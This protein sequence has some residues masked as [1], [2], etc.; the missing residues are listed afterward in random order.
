M[1]GQ[2]PAA[3][4]MTVL[5]NPLHK[6]RERAFAPVDIA[7]LVFFRIAFGLLMMWDV[8]RYFSHHRIGPYW[9]APRLLFKYY[10]FSWVAPW[11]GD[12]LYVHWA[13]LGI[14]ALFIAAGFFYRASVAL[15]CLG[16][17]YT[18][19]LDESK[20]L[21][22]TYLVCLLS[23]LL[24][25]I[26]AHRAFSIDAWRNPKLRAPQV[27]AWTL[28]LLRAQIGMVY[29]FGGVAKISPDWMAGEP[30][31]VWL[32]DKA[33]NPII[34]RLLQEEWGVRALSDAGMVF[35]LG[36]VPLLLWKRTRLAAFFAAV[37]FHLFN[38]YLFYIGFFPWL[39]IA[40][41]TLFLSPS[42]P[43]R[44]L[45]IFSRKSNLVMPEEAAPVG[46]ARQQT[47]LLLAGIYVA[48]Q[49]LVPLRHF[50]YHGG[51]EWMH[52]EH[53]FSWR[54]MLSNDVVQTYFYVTDP[55][56]GQT[57]QVLPED[58]LDHWQASRMGWRPD[59]LM[60][61]AHYLAGVMPR[62][63]LKP[64]RVEGR[65]LVSINGRKPQLV[66]D[67]NVDL[68]SESR[69]FGRPPWLLEIHA[70]LPPREERLGAASADPIFTGE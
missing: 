45:P 2:A 65:I 43:R 70:P 35:D 23:F 58:Y 21:N 40:G 46:P 47:V 33:A 30:M 68:A 18:F 52:A 12:G 56:S 59:M 53:R 38:S 15:F 25:F 34:G 61:F 17:T 29:F 24:I 63:G 31:R 64:L 67:P 41:T 20:W 6:L 10:G 3:K 4:F 50:L 37:A 13:I 55:N 48:I 16:Y 42:W 7:S 51:I 39:A 28:W 54:M 62:T 26:P 22:H 1:T 36:I 49:I 60:Q 69:T 14:L 9:L 5:K 19:L 27:P 11:P 66:I 32:E 57:F 44:L 8:W